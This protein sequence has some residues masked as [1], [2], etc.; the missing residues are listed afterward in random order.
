MHRLLTTAL[1]TI[2]ASTAI[3]RMR[4]VAHPTTPTLRSILPNVTLAVRV[5]NQGKATATAT[6]CADTCKTT[7]LAVGSTTSFPAGTWPAGATLTVTSDQALEA[8]AN[9]DAIPVTAARASTMALPITSTNETILA[10][11]LEPGSIDVGLLGTNGVREAL[12]TLPLHEGRN[13]LVAGFTLTI[14]KQVELQPTVPIIAYALSNGSILRAKALADATGDQ[15]LVRANPET[16]IFLKNP[17]SNALLTMSGNLL[18]P[19]QDNANTGNFTYATALNAGSTALRDFA[20]GSVHLEGLRTSN[21]QEPFL[22]WA[23]H[24]TIQAREEG[25]TARTGQHETAQKYNLSL[26]TLGPTLT[27]LNASRFFGTVTG[28]ITGLDDNGTITGTLS[29]ELRTSENRD[30]DLTSLHAT[31][32]IVS[33]NDNPIEGDGTLPAVLA[34]TPLNGEA[35]PGYQLPKVSTPSLA[36][37]T[38]LGV[39]SQGQALYTSGTT[40]DTRLMQLVTGSTDLTSRI[41]FFG[42]ANTNTNYEEL[43]QLLNRIRATFTPADYESVFNDTQAHLAPYFTDTDGDGYAID[44]GPTDWPYDD[45]TSAPGNQPSGILSLTYRISAGGAEQYVA[46]WLDPLQHQYFYLDNTMTRCLWQA[47]CGTADFGTPLATLLAQSSTSP[48]HDPAALLQSFKDATDGNPANDEIYAGFSP[49][50]IDLRG[51]GTVRLYLAPTGTSIVDWH[52]TPPS[53]TSVYAVIRSFLA[54]YMTANPSAC[55]GTTAC[56][57]TSD[58]GFTN[59]SKPQ[60]GHYAITVQLF[61]RDHGQTFIQTTHPSETT[62]ERIFRI[63]TL[64]PLLGRTTYGCQPLPDPIVNSV[65]EIITTYLTLDPAAQAE[66]SGDVEGFK[67]FLYENYP[68]TATV[69]P[70]DASDPDQQFILS[71]TLSITAGGAEQVV[72][73]LID[74]LH[75]QGYWLNNEIVRCMINGGCGVSPIRDQL[76]NIYSRGI[77][78]TWN[79]QTFQGWLVTMSDGITNANNIE[80]WTK[81]KPYSWSARGTVGYDLTTSS[82]VL[83][84][85]PGTIKLTAADLELNWQ[86]NRAFLVK[87][88]DANPEK[89]CGTKETGPSLSTDCPGYSFT[90]P[91]IYP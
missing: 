9:T 70:C 16:I 27:L 63:T 84:H 35:F 32:V 26:N 40:T 57:L 10:Y 41:G 15:F 11:A 68:S 82:D 23:D 75:Q 44:C 76:A 33:A 65:P 64:Q 87:Y 39:W 48:T 43:Q 54:A 56:D 50:T 22:A 62:I 36:M 19:N 28:T 18:P 90:N 12:T 66:F 91:T 13:D 69:E 49:T 73:Q 72:E 7:L 8:R 14:G 1:L 86:L 79:A 17:V 61:V 55:G 89:G 29:Y 60:T 67:P 52:L 71:I 88:F 30:I 3:G 74:P 47:T 2:L 6:L 81:A 42:Y 46:H 5:T 25:A 34:S 58:P 85:E 77:G 78:E 20:T 31:R 53:T 59:Q 24:R 38:E 45:T 4:A 37:T 51:S 80:L 83:T 21:G